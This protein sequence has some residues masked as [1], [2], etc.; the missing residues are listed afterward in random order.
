MLA[1]E[2]FDFADFL[3]YLDDAPVGTGGVIDREVAD[4][5]E[6]PAALDPEIG[7]V[8][9]LVLERLNDSVDDMDAL[10]RMAVLDGPA[11]DLGAAGE[12]PF[13]GVRIVA[14]AIVL[15]HEGDIEGKSF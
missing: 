1:F 6:G 15:V 4:Q 11:D 8:P 10:G 9:L 3:R 13:S 7:G 5:D 2:G 12:D 14:D